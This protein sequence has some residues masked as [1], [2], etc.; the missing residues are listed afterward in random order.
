MTIAIILMGVAVV[1]LGLTV[2]L[3]GAKV[4]RVEKMAVSLAVILEA[5][6][7]YLSDDPM[8]LVKKAFNHD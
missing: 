3:L 8:E 7:S 6:T 5:K 1:L 4:N 2:V